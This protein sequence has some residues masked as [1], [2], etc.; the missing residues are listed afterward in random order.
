MQRLVPPRGQ[1]LRQLSFPTVTPSVGSAATGRRRRSQIS[2]AATLDPSHAPE[3]GCPAVAA[4][5]T[6][7]G[8]C[9]LRA[10]TDHV[11]D[12]PLCTR[13]LFLP[14]LVDEFKK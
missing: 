6:R 10:E 1:V 11:E 9:S 12:G 5:A 13:L 3:V 8:R 7:G 4:R 2:A 14:L